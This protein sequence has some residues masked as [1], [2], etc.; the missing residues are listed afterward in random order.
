MNAAM[1]LRIDS[2][3]KKDAAYYLSQM[4]LSTS[5]AV[6]LFLHSVVLHKGIP[7]ELKVPNA[8]TRQALKDVD[9]GINMDDTNLAQLTEELNYAR[10][11]AT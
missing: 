8:Q 1:T 4:G 5:E 11:Q 3:V 6:R 2:Q 7:F 9:A 10:H